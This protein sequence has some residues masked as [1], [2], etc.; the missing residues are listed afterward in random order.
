M[1]ELVK[2]D[3]RYKDSFL[4]S[5]KEFVGCVEDSAS[6]RR[7]LK[8]D[9]DAVKDDFSRFIND[10]NALDGERH[11]WVIDNGQYAGRIVLTDIKEPGTV[12]L[13]YE[14]R[15]KMRG[16]GLAS[17][18]MAMAK[19]KANEMGY[20]K[21]L[22]ICDPENIASKKVITKNGGE[23]LETFTNDMGVEKIRYLIR[24]K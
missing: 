8:I 14:I 19:E 22:I 23:I 5:V 3:E 2:P 20:E 18:A 6:A 17:Q 4:E 24:V 12:L 7:Y 10:I 21:I 15:P 11:L 1:V 9:Y 16:K 13:S